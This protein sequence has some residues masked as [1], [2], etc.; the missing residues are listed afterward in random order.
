MTRCG[1]VWTIEYTRSAQKQIAKLDSVSRKRIRAFLEERLAHLDNPR[2]I[3]KT[4][5]TARYE[6]IWRYRA[7]PFR[8]LTRIE[9]ARITIL[10]LEVDDRKDIYRR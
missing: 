10:V 4:L 7:G 2:Q 3:G 1:V 5:E 9:D 6:G 8:I